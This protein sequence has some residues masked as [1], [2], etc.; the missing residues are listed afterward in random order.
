VLRSSTIVGHA[1]VAAAVLVGCGS[2]DAPDAP[3]VFEDRARGYRFPVE[4]GWFVLADE[5][6]S[7]NRSNLTVQ[8]HSLDGA[9]PAFVAGLP[10]SLV[11]QLEAWARYYFADVGSPERRPTV[12]DGIDALELSYPVRVR[13][14]DAAGK[15]LYWV[16]QRGGRLYTFRAAVPPRAPSSDE[17]DLRRMISRLEFFDD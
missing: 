10:E 12:V 16:I 7:R 8:V 1:L 5:V 6:G 11:P 4:P 15:V 3:P 13:P 17:A 9:E 14:R 2:S